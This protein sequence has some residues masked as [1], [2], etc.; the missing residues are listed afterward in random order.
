VTAVR[1]APY[2]T[3]ALIQAK[4]YGP[5]TTVGSPDVQQYASLKQQRQGV[6][7]VVIVTTNEFTGQARELAQ[8]LNVKLVNGDEL[9]GMVEQ[10][11]AHDLVRDYLNLPE[12]DE[13]EDKEDETAEEAETEATAEVPEA[14]LDVSVPPTV[15]RWGI[16]AGTVGW[17]SLFGL[18]ENVSDGVFALVF[19]FSWFVLPVSIHMDTKEVRKRNEDAFRYPWAYVAGS[20]VWFVSILVGVAYLWRVRSVDAGAGVKAGAES[21]EGEG[22]RETGDDG[23]EDGGDGTIDEALTHDGTEYACTEE[24]AADGWTVYRGRGEDNEAALVVRNGEVVVSEEVGSVVAADVTED[25][26]VAVADGLDDRVPSGRFVVLDADGERLVTH[27]FNSDIADC[28]VT[29]G[30]AAVSTASPDDTTYVFD[31]ETGD[32][33]EHPNLRGEKGNVRF[34]EED[35]ETVVAVSGDSD[36]EPLYYVNADGEVVRKSDRLLRRERLDELLEGGREKLEE[37]VEELRER[38]DESEGEAEPAVELADAR[39]AL[40]NEIR[41][42]EGVTDEFWEYLEAA[43]ESYYDAAPRYDGRQGVAEVLRRQS[44][45]YVRRNADEAALSRL[46]EI[47]ELEEYEGELLTEEDRKRIERLS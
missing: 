15:W 21:S 32:A 34:D 43:K 10:L 33:S 14:D 42:D 13:D 31:T 6:D 5:N 9:A 4:R 25:G 47:E 37:A 28:A 45:Y 38:Y 44:E 41:E 39:L 11:D 19:L 23:E 2:R 22:V 7:K 18:V 16:A 1:H 46:R 3:K 24:A 12:P 27:L 29:D 26:V 8:S 40:A 20:A 35:G 36:D 17:L 30:H